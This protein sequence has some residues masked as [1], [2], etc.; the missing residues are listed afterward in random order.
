MIYKWS[1]PEEVANQ[2]IGLYDRELSYDQF[3]LMDGMPESSDFRFVLRYTAWKK[4]IQPLDCLPNNSCNEVVNEDVARIIR[5]HA[6][7]DCVLHPAEVY[8][9]DGPLEGYYAVIVT[10]FVDAL[11]EELSRVTY[12]EVDPTQLLGMERP[13]YD[14]SAMSQCQLARERRYSPH[15]LVGDKLAN[16][17]MAIKAKGVYFRPVGL[18]Q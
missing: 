1:I 15:I 13:T 14:E 2:Q 5:Q 4:R 18:D 10:S 8:C 7:D 3:D 6:A 12:M 16:A 17:I 11:V 9:K